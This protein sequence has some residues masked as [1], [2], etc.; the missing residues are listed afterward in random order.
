LYL[1]AAKHTSLVG[2]TKKSKEAVE[3]KVLVADAIADLGVEQLQSAGI[4][5]AVKTKLGPEELVEEIKDYDA[6]IVRSATKVTKDV[7]AAGTK[8]KIIG[9][10][11][12]GLDNVDVETATARGI[13]VANAPEGN[14][15]SAAEHTIALLMSQA[16]RIPQAN[17]CL[18]EGE[19]NRKLKGVEL[20]DKVLGVV[21]LG[22]V[23][24]LVAARAKG[25]EMQVIAFD[26][27]VSKER[28][29]ELGIK[30]VDNLDDLLR[31][32]DF[33][34]IHLPLTDTTKSLIGKQ[35]IGRMKE[36]VRI[37]NTARGGIIDEGAL[38]QAIED[39]KVAGAALDVFS[40][41]PCTSSKLFNFE[42]VVVTPHL[43]ASTV[44]AQDRAGIIIA[45]QVI[46]GLNG[47]FVSNAVNIAAA[48]VEE[49]VKPFLPLAEK[50]GRLLT[51]IASTPMNTIEIEYAG[52]IANYDISI[53]TVAALKGLFTNVIH[54]PVTFVNAP[55]LAKERGLDVKEVKTKTAKDYISTITVVGK[56]TDIWISAGG[57][58]IG[59]NNQE[60]FVNIYDFDIDMVPSEYMAFFQYEDKPGMIGKVG[61]ILGE[62][63]I[64]IANMQVG[65]KVVGG[66]ALMGINVD[67]PISDEIMEDIKEQAGI[68]K[69]LFI[70]L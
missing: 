65:R 26:P 51:H 34:T 57:T 66:D 27:Y 9:R 38:T 55:L 56:D 46:A 22:R 44:E 25:F 49:A 63:G 37:I 11:G 3:I 20:Y 62:S 30:M 42:Q 59:K 6:I 54:E 16:R 47:E 33:I 48:S 45:Q 39:G 43:G 21:G 69:G 10:A 40:K 13:M 58:L 14:V 8:L 68:E 70:V 32:A 28:F 17:V 36:G 41:E 60:R 31:Q 12:I 4:E 64:N 19:W 61:T 7:I 35:E 67:V 53:L 15:I 23:G 18:K 29:Q 1:G 50:L 5:V 24:A 2:L 52:K